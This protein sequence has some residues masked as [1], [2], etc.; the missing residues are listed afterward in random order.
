MLNAY[1]VATGN[2]SILERALPLATVGRARCQKAVLI[3]YSGGDGMVD[4]QQDYR[5]YITL[6]KPNAYGSSLRCQ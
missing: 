4:N 1:V 3:P 5:C 6:Y 2:I